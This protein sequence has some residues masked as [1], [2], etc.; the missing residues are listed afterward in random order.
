MRENRNDWVD[1]YRTSEDYTPEELGTRLSFSLCFSMFRAIPFNIS[2]SSLVPLVEPRYWYDPE[3]GRLNFDDVKKQMLTSSGSF[4]DRG[5][6]AMAPEDWSK[7]WDTWDEP[8]SPYFHWTDVHSVLKIDDGSDANTLNFVNTISSPSV[9]AD[10]SIRG[11]VL[12]ILRS[13]GTTAEAVQSMLM[14]ALE[15]RYQDYL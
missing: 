14:V 2:A 10:V 3:S 6:L 9:R 13:N 11:L 12:D 1:L 15:S 8:E 7:I 4:Q 5:I